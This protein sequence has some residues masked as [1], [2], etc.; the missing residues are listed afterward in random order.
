MTKATETDSE[1]AIET[2][3][4]VGGS[5]RDTTTCSGGRIAATDSGSAA[6]MSIAR[7]TGMALFRAIRMDSAEAN[8]ALI[9]L[10]LLT[11]RVRL[12]AGP[13]FI[14]NRD[15]PIERVS[16]GPS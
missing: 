4:L 10:K 6:V 2:E 13:F 9:F 5:I 12:P 8:E 15:L 1:W 14:G 7:T 16:H 3:T 11:K